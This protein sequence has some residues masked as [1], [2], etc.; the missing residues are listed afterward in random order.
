MLVTQLRVYGVAVEV[1]VEA[2][3]VAKVVKTELLHVLDCT[4]VEVITEP[5]TV[6]VVAMT[7]PV[8]CCNQL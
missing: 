4:M 1:I 2:E 6:I 3:Q 8:T 7:G 5:G